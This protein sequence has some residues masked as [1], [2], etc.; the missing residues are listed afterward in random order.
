MKKSEMIRYVL[1]YIMG[2]IIF[3]ILIPSLIYFV[4]S[5]EG[6]FFRMS[7]IDS[8]AIRFIIV[9][10]LLSV[11]LVFTIWSNIDLFRIGNGGTT[12]FFNVEISPRSKNLI[13]TGPYRFTRNPMVF[14]VNSI[15]FAISF[16][17]NSLASL[18]FCILFIFAVTL[19]LKLTEEKR[20]LQD[21][22][23]EYR[24]YKKRVPMIIPFTNRKLSG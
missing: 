23:N 6:D 16:V 18:I 2:I 12:D 4:S 3:L 17:I 13:I 15:Y 21:F 11:G 10:L 1:G 19:Y 9:A 20:L 24:D 22:R 14:G 8:N 7:I 5:I